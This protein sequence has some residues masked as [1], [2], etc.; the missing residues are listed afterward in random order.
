ML[1]LGCV[2]LEAI[3]LQL[4]IRIHVLQPSIALLMWRLLSLALKATIVLCL[5]L[6]PSLVRLVFI[7][8]VVPVPQPLVL[9]ELAVLRQVFGVQEAL[10][11]S[12]PTLL[13]HV[14]QEHIVPR[15]V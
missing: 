6:P 15:I 3:A 13:S 2:T 7:V 5:F 8:T 10:N 9:A 14:Q 4:P 1:S 11:A 12:H